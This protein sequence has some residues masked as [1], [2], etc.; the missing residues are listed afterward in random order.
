M[1]KILIIE[2][3]LSIAE[4][5]KDYLE[6]DKFE[7]TDSRQIFVNG[8]EVNLAQKEFDLPVLTEIEVK[9]EDNTLSP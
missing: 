4:L 7:V 9:N 5:Q 6:L 3:D 8:S 2:D 1:K